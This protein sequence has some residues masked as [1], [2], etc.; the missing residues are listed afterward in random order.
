MS[1]NPPEGYTLE[2]NGRYWR[3]RLF[4]QRPDSETYFFRSSAVRAAWKNHKRVQRKRLKDAIERVERAKWK[5][6]EGG[7]DNTTDR[8]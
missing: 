5:L 1:K 3:W 7:R 4:K 6:E 2:S 8:S